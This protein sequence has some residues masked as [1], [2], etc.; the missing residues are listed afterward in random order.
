MNRNVHQPE[1]SHSYM[2]FQATAFKIV[3]NV[4][5]ALRH[6]FVIILTIIPMLALEAEMLHHEKQSKWK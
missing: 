4:L 3:F 6:N 5:V 1:C 2:S